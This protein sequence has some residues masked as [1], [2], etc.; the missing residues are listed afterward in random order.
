MAYERKT[1]DRWDIITN[2]GYGFEC[3]CSE[4]T[5][6]EACQR[7]REYRENCGELCVAT[8]EKHRERIAAK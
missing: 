2:Y 6:K 1:R 8:I 4:Y 5:Y 7:L 3:E